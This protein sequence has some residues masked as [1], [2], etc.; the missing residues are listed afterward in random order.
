MAEVPLYGQ[1][2]RA[3]SRGP[4]RL[5]RQQAGVFWQGKIIEKTAKRIILGNPR[6][7]SVGTPGISDLGGLTSRVITP[8]DVGRLVAIYLAIEVK[9]KQPVTT[10]QRNF[11]NTVLSLGGRAGIAHSVDEAQHIIEGI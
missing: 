10:E 6:A 9:D 2:M 1:I 7:I 3:W 4:T 8:D 11:I 5:F